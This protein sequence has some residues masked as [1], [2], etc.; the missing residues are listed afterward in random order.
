ML[1]LFT[2]L[3]FAI[4]VEPVFSQSYDI[5]GSTLQLV[6]YADYHDFEK[7]FLQPDNDTLYVI[8]FWATWCAPCVKELPYFV[9][10][11][12]TLADQPVAFVYVSLDFV[13]QIPTKLIPFLIGKSFDQKVVVLTDPDTNHWIDAIDPNWSGAIP[14][15]LLVKGSKKLGIEQS[16]HNQED[17]ISFIHSFHK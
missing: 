6:Q 3:I 14:Y 12:Q 15:T 1:R 7:A 11:S 9:E 5:N 13:R 17:I 16:F 4:A 2:L 10:A 8:N